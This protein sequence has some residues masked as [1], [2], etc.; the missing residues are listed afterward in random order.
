MEAD[1]LFCDVA[2]DEPDTAGENV[3]DSVGW[4]R[5]SFD[6]RFI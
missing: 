2:V 3:G 4:M 1:L 5:L 6:I